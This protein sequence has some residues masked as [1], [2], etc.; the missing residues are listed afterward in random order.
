MST[1]R[2]SIADEKG[3]ALPEF[4]LV[5]PV[6]IL[7]LFG[8]VDFGRGFNYWNDA[9]HISAEGAR[10]AVVNRRPDPNSAASLQVQLRDQ[11]DTADLRTGGSSTLPTPAQVCITFPNGTSNIGDPVQVAMTFTYHWLPIMDTVSTLID[12]NKSF[13]AT[14]TFTARSV[15]R[16][17]APPTTYG[18]GCA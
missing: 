5:L 12:K 8:I 6:L 3:Q 14:T 13:V 2:R 1:L 18:A 17:E 11:A 4:A 7:V 9:T 10:F 16:I 15:M